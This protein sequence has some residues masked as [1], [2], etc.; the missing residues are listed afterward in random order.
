MILRNLTDDADPNILHLGP[1]H[2]KRRGFNPRHDDYSRTILDLKNRFP[3]AINYFFNLLDPILDY[4]FS[5]VTIP[6]SDPLTTHPGIRQLGMRL[7][8]NRRIDATTCLVRHTRIPKLASGGDRDISQ[9]EGSISV[10]DESLIRGREVLLLDDVCTS[11][12]SLIAGWGLLMGAGA[13]RVKCVSLGL[14]VRD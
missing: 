1:Y 4:G 8:A 6:S 14:T 2:P 3:S 11:G 12:N 5:I 7:A 13:V 10:V 9:H